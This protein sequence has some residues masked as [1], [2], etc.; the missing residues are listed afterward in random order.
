M[1][2]MYHL[3][4]APSVTIVSAMSLGRT[5]ADSYLKQNVVIFLATILLLRGIG[6]GFLG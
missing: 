6:F 1:V 5:H 3:V 2:L 4:A